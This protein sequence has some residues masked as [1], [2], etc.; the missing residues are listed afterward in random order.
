SPEDGQDLTQ[1]FFSVFLEKKYFGLANRERGRFRSFLVASFKHFLANEFKRG[2]TI[3]RGG[4]YAFVSWDETQAE[5]RY[6]NEPACETTPDALFEH[7]WALTLLEKVM[8]DLHRE[9]ASAGKDR[10]FAALEVFLSGEK[11]ETTYAEIGE[12]LRLSESAVKMSVS[13]LR[14]RYGQL[15]RAEIANTVIDAASVEDE[16]RHLLSALSR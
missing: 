8:K 7:A 13:R 10:L 12:G 11:T 5:A 16:L 14:R 2:R 15:L 4:Q 1:Q 6:G 3:K 9:Y